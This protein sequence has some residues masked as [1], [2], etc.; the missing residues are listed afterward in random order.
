MA[1]A[2]KRQ[3]MYHIMDKGNEEKIFR[4][5]RMAQQ[6]IS[7]FLLNVAYAWCDMLSKAVVMATRVMPGGALSYYVKRSKRTHVNELSPQRSTR[8]YRY[9]G[10]DMDYGS[11]DLRPSPS[12]SPAESEMQARHQEV[13]KFH[14]GEC[15]GS[16]APRGRGSD[17]SQG[18]NHSSQDDLGRP[19]RQRA[20]SYGGLGRAA[21]QFYLASTILALEALHTAGFVYR[22]L[23]DKNLLLDGAGRARLCDYGL[24]HDLASGLASG[25]S[26]T[27]GYWAPEQLERRKKY[28]TTCDL[29]TLGVCAYHWATGEKPFTDAD[30]DAEQI[31]LKIL[32]ADYD[33]SRMPQFERG[34]PHSDTTE[35]FVPHL[36]ELCAGLMTLEPEGR[37]GVVGL[38]LD[39]LKTHPFFDGLDWA[40]LYAGALEPPI[41]PAQ[42]QI[43]ADLP[44]TIK[45]DFEEWMSRPVPMGAANV[46]GES[47]NGR[48]GMVCAM[49]WDGIVWDGMA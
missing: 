3:I 47:F 6:V 39:T 41:K 13:L 10:R 32:A 2:L 20:G 5:V 49:G 38:G 30:N 11:D 7:P 22:D 23:K 43:V 34:A 17:S 25:R 14:G 24:S 40:K 45:A 33:T 44:S 46:F 16:S 9:S 48:C 36:K 19:E 8:S 21:L 12:R 1:F 18:T 29:W 27:K 28:T 31:R 15:G 4:E 35:Y 42:G 37:L 26:G